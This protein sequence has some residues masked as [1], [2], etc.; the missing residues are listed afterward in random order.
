[1]ELPVELTENLI[2]RGSILH[3]DIFADI[4]H[5]K[6]FVIIG[7]DKDFIAGFFFINSNINKAIWNKE[8]QLAMQYHLKKEDYDFLRYNS[9]LN[10]TN[11]ITRSRK[12]LSE[13]IREGRTSMI[14]HLKQ[15]HL[16][17]V[18]DMVRNSK[19]FN[20]IEKSRFFYD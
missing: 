5:G 1:M 12:E 2:E 3:S 7:V 4:D 16:D 18:L 20:K 15:E 17:D 13:S 19:L 11:I 10:A 9:F 8:D 6:F 14:G